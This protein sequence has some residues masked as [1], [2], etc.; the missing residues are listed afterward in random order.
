MRRFVSTLLAVIVLFICAL[1]GTS[2][3]QAAKK[4][5]VSRAIAIVFDNS[6]SMYYNEETEEKLKAWCRATYAMEGFAAMLNKGDTLQIYPMHPINVGDK[7]YSMQN[8]LQ[9]TDASQAKII[10]NIFTKLPAGTPIESIDYAADGLKKVQADKKYMIVLS[11]GSTFSMNG[12]DMNEDQTVAELDKRIN[13]Y[14]GSSMNVMYLATGQAANLPSVEEKSYF[15]KRHAANT[16]DVLSTLTSMCNLIF[17]RDSVSSKYITKNSVDF[18]ISMSKLIVFVQG[19][20]ITDLEVKSAS[21]KTVGKLVSAQQLK[22]ATK[23]QGYYD[24]E[25]AVDDSLQGMIVT[26]EDCSAGKYVISYKGT[27]NTVDAYYEPD[28]DLEFVFTDASGNEV[29]PNALYEGDY[30]VSFGMKDGKTGKLISSDLLGKPRYQGSYFINGVEHSITHEGFSG[31]VDIPLKMGDKFEANLT[32]TYLSGYVISK[33]STEFGWPEGGIQIA[34]RPAGDFRLEVSGGSSEISLQ[35]LEKAEPY[36][37][38]VYYQ[39][40]Q[41]TGSELE[42]VNLQIGESNAEIK[43]EFAEDH[44]KLSLH[45]KDP[46]NPQNTACGECTVP[47][48]AT[49]TAQGSAEAKAQGAITYDIK[50]TGFLK[51]TLTVP[52]TYIVIKD[53]ENTKEIVADFEFNGEPLNPADF[54]NLKVQVDCGGIEHT[55]TP[56][57]GKSSYIIKLLPTEGIEAGDYKIKVSATYSDHIGRE[58]N[59]EEDQTITLSTIPMW[60][61]WVI[62]ISILILLIILIWMILHKRVLPKRVRHEVDGCSL[63]VGG[64]NVTDD[65]TFNAKLSG[66]QLTTYVEYNGDEIGRVSVSRVAPGKESY[67]YKSS[68]RRSIL[69]KHPENISASGE[70]KKVDV[71]GV[72]YVVNNEGRIMAADEQQG[73][74]TITN[75]NSITINGKTMVA[76]RMKS[77][78]AEIQLNFKKK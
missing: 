21:G 72:E 42:A 23:G 8:P 19:D 11:D 2:S 16:E 78:S 24:I 33:N 66:K 17:G 73:P 49:Y 60:L 12:I 32:V 58:T 52:E 75:G 3:V 64:Q 35:D 20:N 46:E 5:E 4:T 67:L 76:G 38:K 47:L 18:D 45:Y 53:I 50:D 9:I 34:A 63:S 74:Y 40:K 44:Y 36:I 65:A 39:D 28:A 51:M 62:V 29:D 27:A 10:E 6:G 43:K 77:F 55:V 56:D 25:D 1:S 15:I 59:V 69:V 37:V 57:E 31:K 13:K 61:K 48:V 70:V 41:L 54:A 26:Y 30:V 7:V 71:A 68:V 22:Y 14:A